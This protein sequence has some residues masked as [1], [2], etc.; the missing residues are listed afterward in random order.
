MHLHWKKHETVKVTCKPCKPGQIHEYAE[1]LARLSKGIVIDLKPDN[2]IIFY[3]G[4]NYVQPKIMSP[5]DTLS[6]DKVSL[7]SFFFLISIFF[8]LI[9]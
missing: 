5:P 1:E 4:K 7:P 2:T 8:Q 3:R 9:I 6:K